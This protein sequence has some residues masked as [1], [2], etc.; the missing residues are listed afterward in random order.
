[1]GISIFSHASPS[2]TFLPSSAKV[3]LSILPRNSIQFRP[4]KYEFKR[5]QLIV[6]LSRDVLKPRLF[7]RDPSKVGQP[8]TSGSGSAMSF[9]FVNPPCHPADLT[10]KYATFVH[11][12]SSQHLCS[13]LYRVTENLLVVTSSSLRCLHEPLHE[14]SLYDQDGESL[15]CY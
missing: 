6:Q 2:L 10:F 8:S 5:P 1:M 14:L 7:I 11:P 15:N 13:S 9:S 4:F 12:P 3:P